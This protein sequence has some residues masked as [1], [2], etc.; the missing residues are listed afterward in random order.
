[1]SSFFEIHDR[2]VSGN[3]IEVSRNSKINVENVI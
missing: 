3:V 2:K 1:M